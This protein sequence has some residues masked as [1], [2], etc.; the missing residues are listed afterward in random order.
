MRLTLLFFTITIF[1]CQFTLA[2]DEVNQNEQRKINSLLQRI[3]K[4][5]VIFIRNG[6]EYSPKEAH[7]HLKRKLDYALNSWFAPAKNKWTAKM[8]IEEIAS[9]SSFSKKPYQ[10]KLKNG[11]VLNTETW[12]KKLLKEIEKK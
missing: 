6:S 7:D 3:K 8:F 12:L 4:S 5:E 9:K 2:K 10:I 11:E 1:L